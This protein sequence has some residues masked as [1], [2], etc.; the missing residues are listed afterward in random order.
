MCEDDYKRLPG[1]KGSLKRDNKVIYRYRRC[2]FACSH[3]T[4]M[5]LNVL[6]SCRQIYDEADHILWTSN[7]FSLA[8]GITFERFMADRR[9]QQR[10]LIRSLR[11]E[12]SWYNTDDIC[13]WNKALSTALVSSLS[14]LQTL[15]LQIVHDMTEHTWGKV[16]HFFLDR[17]SL[18]DGLRR[19]STLPLK[20]VEVAVRPSP[21]VDLFIG[22]DRRPWSQ[23]DRETVAKGVQK[24]LLDS[25][26]AEDIKAEIGQIRRE[27]QTLLSGGTEI[28]PRTGLPSTY[29]WSRK[30]NQNDMFD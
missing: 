11:L 7:T 16:N 17:T 27:R 9:I 13:L 18:C 21:D 19:L 26:S 4:T 29:L 20:N 6:R 14:G 10:R 22:V 3:D 30:D 8:N 23:K 28:I 12:M 24:I 15:R 1:G 2:F 5:H 25:R